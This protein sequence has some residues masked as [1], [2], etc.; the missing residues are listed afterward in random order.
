MVNEIRKATD[1]FG[2]APF[3]SHFRTRGGAEVDLVLE[4]DGWLYPIEFKAKSN[5]TAKD[6]NGILAFREAMPGQRIADG[7]V[8]SAVVEPRRINPHVLAVPWWWIG[9]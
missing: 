2:Q 6:G 9:Q 5:P 4:R 3:M 7:L 8:V 1:C